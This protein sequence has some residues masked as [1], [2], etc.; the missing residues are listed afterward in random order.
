MLYLETI[1]PTED[2]ILA[3]LRDSSL[4]GYVTSI[5]SSYASLVSGVY[6]DVLSY[7]ALGRSIENTSVIERNP[8]S[9]G[10]KG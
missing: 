5:V 6:G 9:Q 4:H 2:W 3:A 8:Y 10:A 1:I 7:F